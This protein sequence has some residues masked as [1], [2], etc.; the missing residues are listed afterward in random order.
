MRHTWSLMFLLFV[1]PTLRADGPADNIPEKVRRIPP[2]GVQI[3]DADRKELERGVAELGR[4]IE[5]LKTALKGKPALLELLPDVQIY[6]KA[7]D[8]GLRYDEFFNQKNPAADVK[9]ARGLLSTGME[10][11]TALQEGKSPWTTATGLVVRGYLS[12]IDGS[13][14]PYGLVVPSTYKPDYPH[15]YRLDIWCHGRGETLSELGFIQQ[16]QSLPGEFTPPNAFVLH[17]YGRYCNANKLAGEVDVLEA[18][19]HVQKH[20]AVDDDRIIMRG[21]S[22]GGAACWQFAVHY[23]DKWCAAAPGAGFSETQD[24]LKVFQNESIQPSEYEQKLWHLYDCTDYALNLFNL[25]TVAYSGEIDK[26]KQAADMMAKALKKEGMELTHIIGPKTAHAYHPEAKKEINRRI[27]LIAANGRNQLPKS[28]KFSTYTLR[29]NHSFWITIDEMAE[30]WQ[31]ARVEAEIRDKETIFIEAKGVRALTI[32]MPAGSCPLDL[33]AP[34]VVIFGDGQKT[35][36]FAQTKPQSDRSWVTHWRRTN[37]SNNEP[38]EEIIGPEQEKEL[39]KRHGLQGPIDDAFMDRFLMVRPTGTPLNEKVGKWADAEMKHAIEHWRRQ[40]RGDAPVKDDTD[41]TAA[42]ITESNLVLWGDP[43]SNALLK[44]I[45]NDLPIG[46]DAGHVRA[47]ELYD[48]GHHVPVLIYP[49]PLNPKKYVVVNSG[50]TF[51]EY[52]YLNNARQVPKLPDWA[53][54]DIDSPVTS[55][56]PGKVVNAGFCNEHWLVTVRK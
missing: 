55:R 21:F 18:L 15:R 20:Y 31:E 6:H 39:R 34:P 37:R 22:M 48:A 36:N 51:R 9:A 19:E 47:V 54:V 30:H 29:Y 11:A 35:G 53:I 16:R 49:N 40:F 26:Q 44:K 42:D 43:S 25:P 45:A 23:P 10:R 46:W 56:A 32:S 4:E 1:I 38:W 33:L 52:D 28:V 41:V 14:Q 17:P 12:K 13:V 5:G 2:P 27:D 7:V 50:F 8:W 3:P 24:F